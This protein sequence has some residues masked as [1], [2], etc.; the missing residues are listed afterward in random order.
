MN[1]E[2]SPPHPRSAEPGRAPVPRRAFVVAPVGRRW[3]VRDRIRRTERVFD[4]RRA[5]IHFA[6]FEACSTAAI[7]VPEPEAA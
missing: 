3:V 6:L 1:R 7:V 4:E 5:A 2:T